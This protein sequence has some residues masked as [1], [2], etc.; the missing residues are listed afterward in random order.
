M[1]LYCCSG[2][3]FA[4]IAW[5]RFS[6]VRTATV[7]IAIAVAAAASGRG[8]SIGGG[9]INVISAAR[10]D[11]SIIGT[12]SASIVSVIGDAASARRRHNFA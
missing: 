3:V 8:E 9:P 7:G 2:P 5:R 4:R 6:C 12:G 1:K 10:K 11:G